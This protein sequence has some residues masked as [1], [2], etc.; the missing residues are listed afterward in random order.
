VEYLNKMSQRKYIMLAILLLFV[1]G[2][3]Y[4]G[5]KKLPQGK[6]VAVPENS[7]VYATQ[8]VSLT[9]SELNG[10]NLYYKECLSCHGSFRKNDGPWLSL[11]GI[12]SQ[13]PDKKELFAFIRNPAEVITRNAYARKLE[14]V[15]GL[16]MT[17]FPDLTDVE[18]QSI[19]DYIKREKNSQE[20]IIQ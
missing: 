8:N 3:I 17:G 7:V 11:A 4:L 18:I 5:F 6:C 20:G 16:A 13:W 2:L 19:L 1:G 10:K 14:E 12:E 15:Y 9:A